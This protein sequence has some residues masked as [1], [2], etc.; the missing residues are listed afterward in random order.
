M[1]P[2]PLVV[3]RL[4]DEHDLDMPSPPLASARYDEQ[5]EYETAKLDRVFPTMRDDGIVKPG[6]A[7][8]ISRHPLSEADHPCDASSGAI[9]DEVI[10]PSRTVEIE[11]QRPIV[12][13][14]D[15]VA[16]EPL[17]LVHRA[18]SPVRV[19]DDRRNAGAGPVEHYDPN[20]ARAWTVENPMIHFAAVVIVES[21]CQVV[22]RLQIVSTD[23]AI[24]APRLA[25][26]IEYLHDSGHASLNH[27]WDSRKREESWDQRTCAADQEETDTEPNKSVAPRQRAK[28]T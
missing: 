13:R 22:A 3:S 4:F 8:K 24:G 2:H 7:A 25:C 26:R 12:D 19:L 23:P 21:E 10:Q 15:V 5:Q 17:S 27:R 16:R 20:P 6:A 18:E 28:K 11:G 14:H 1:N 9:K